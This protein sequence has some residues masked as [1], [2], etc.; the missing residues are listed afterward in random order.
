M[1]ATGRQHGVAGAGLDAGE[2]VEPVDL[3]LDRRTQ[4]RHRRR[5]PLLLA[6]HAVEFAIGDQSLIDALANQL[7]QLPLGIQFAAGN[8]QPGLKTTQ[9]EVGIDRLRRDA[10]PNRI[11]IGGGTGQVC[12]RG[13][14]AAAQAAEQIDLPRGLRANLVERVIAREAERVAHRADGRLQRLADAIGRSV[15]T[16]RRQQRRTG[17]VRMRHAPDRAGRRCGNVAILRERLRHQPIEHGIGKAAPPCRVGSSRRDGR[18]AVKGGRKRHAGAVIIGADGAAGEGH[19]RQERNKK[20][21]HISPQC[22][23]GGGAA[24]SWVGRQNGT[25]SSAAT[26]IHAIRRNTSSNAIVS[27]SRPTTRR[28]RHAPATAPVPDRR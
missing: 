19:R 15:G 14:P 10:E 13:L 22:A 7:D 5:N 17:R 12:P 16:D 28:I 9:L 24:V 20:A 25:I 8:R 6:Q 3:A 4:R 26:N 23:S 2:N 1:A 11:G 18:R 27:A 21:H